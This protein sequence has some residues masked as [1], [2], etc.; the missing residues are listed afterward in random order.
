M[1]TRSDFYQYRYVHPSMNQICFFK[2]F[3]KISLYR[4]RLIDFGLN[5]IL[6]L[7]TVKNNVHDVFFYLSIE[8]F[9]Y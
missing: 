4:S 5:H 3:L 6:E 7:L 2:A 1:E 8:L 9:S